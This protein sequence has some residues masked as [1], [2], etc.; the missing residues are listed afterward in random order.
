V[1]LCVNDNISQLIQYIQGVNV[2]DSLQYL[3]T[4]MRNNTG[5]SRFR[6]CPL[7]LVHT[8]GVTITNKSQFFILGII[9]FAA[10]MYSDLFTKRNKPEV[11]HN[12]NVTENYSKSYTFP[13]RRVAAI[14]NRDVT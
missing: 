9:L 11:Y 4:A 13:S 1:K 6:F 8:S 12:H 2:P 7:W 5:N 3:F 10:A 14:F